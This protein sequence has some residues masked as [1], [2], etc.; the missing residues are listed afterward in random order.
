MGIPFYFK[1]LTSD[2][3]DIVTPELPAH[4]CNRLFL[5]FNCGIHFCVGQIK[6]DQ[7]AKH[8]NILSHSSFE[9]LLIKKCCELIED[10]AQCAAPS[11]LL[12]VSIDG[13]P[14]MAKI[15]QQRKR[16]YFSD[17]RRTR[18]LRRMQHANP[19][20]LRQLKHEWNSNCITPG[21]KFM[22]QLMKSLNTFCRE[23][24]CSHK[25]KVVFSP[26]Q[27]YGEGEHKICHYIQQHDCQED[28][29]D[30]IY[31]LDADM[32]LLG[33]LS[34]NSMN[35]FLMREHAFY[36]SNTIS[37]GKSMSY[38]FLDIKHTL[39]CVCQQWCS[40]L[41]L[42]ESPPPPSATHERSFILK[43]YVVL[44]FLL[45]NDFIPHLSHLR[46]RENGL[47]TLL[48]A[49]RTTY[50]RCGT[51][52]ILPD[53][54][55]L[56]LPFL[57]NFFE[58][59]SVSEDIE[60]RNAE[61]AYFTRTPPNIK[62]MLPANGRDD[63]KFEIKKLDFYPILNKSSLRLFT[64]NMQGWRTNYYFHLFDKD[65]HSNVVTRACASYL[66]GLVWCCDYYFKQRTNWAWFY[67][68]NYSPTILDLYNYS[69]SLE[70][71]SN[72][73]SQDVGANADYVKVHEQLLMVIP[74]SSKFI[75]PNSEH[76]KYI[77][78]I[79]KGFVHTFPVDFEIVT[80]LKSQLHECS[81]SGLNLDEKVSI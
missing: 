77:T 8:K 22:E 44:T 71:L 23:F 1:K 36:K 41:K 18:L 34:K 57:L 2:F 27:E 12:Y 38:L 63:L 9:S 45:G 5:D 40:F 28:W 24:E 43:C 81:G 49:Y 64:D 68:Y 60:F 20:H 50:E 78:D 31:G 21:T 15:T 76:I 11:D 3:S 75:I 72:F 55:D 46:L 47:E 14:P 16:R 19:E 80:Y 35:T 39:T 25:I 79:N 67:K 62:S 32:I 26:C 7:H 61:E 53:K 51:H 4:K 42:G 54:D 10:L 13:V 37:G 29:I 17:W 6:E 65:P 59:L 73:T 56:N 52:I 30:V 58:I 74:P 33:M 70:R 48:N 69:S 66:Q